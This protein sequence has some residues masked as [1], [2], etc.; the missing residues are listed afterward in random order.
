MHSKLTQ[1]RRQLRE[2]APLVIAYSGGVDSAYLLAE[3]HRALGAQALGVIADSPSLPRQALAEALALAAKMGARVEVIRT[4]EFDNPSYTSNPVNRC[5]Y[6]KAELFAK[7]E[8]LASAREFRAI[9]YGE[10]ADD[11]RQVRPGRQ[12]AAEFAIIAPLRDAG[13]SK[14]EIRA[15]S[16]ELGLPTADAPAQPC[17]SSR[18]PHGTPVT[19]AALALVERGEA[20]VRSLGFRV[21]RVRHLAAPG[22][23]ARARLQIAPEEMGRLAAL[24][25]ALEAGLLAEGYTTVEIDPAGYRTGG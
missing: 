14:A 19:T 24:R 15:L 12:A 18:I 5:Y 6:C 9:A 20:F 4:E 10:N 11:M 3:A 16:R 2:N 8:A 17:L 13:L 7:L 25:P 21:F 22:Q 1:L 23:P